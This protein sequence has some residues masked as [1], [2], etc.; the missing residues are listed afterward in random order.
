MADESPMRMEVALRYLGASVVGN[1]QL[2]MLA[3]LWPG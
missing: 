3:E 2:V 1:N